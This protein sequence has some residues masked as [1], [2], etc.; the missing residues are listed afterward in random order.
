[1]PTPVAVLKEQSVVQ[2]DPN[3]SLKSWLQTARKTY[4]TAELAEQTRDP[5]QTYVAWMKWAGSAPV[6]A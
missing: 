6:L 1:M 3:Y 2:A 5:E 4:S